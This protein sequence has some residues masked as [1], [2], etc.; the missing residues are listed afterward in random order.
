MNG[1]RVTG[2]GGAYLVIRTNWADETFDTHMSYAGRSIWLLFII[3]ICWA[4]KRCFSNP[5]RLT[6]RLLFLTTYQVEM[7]GLSP[8]SALTSSPPFLAFAD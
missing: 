2:Q 3:I 1:R 7:V 8:S 4:V 5:G 6:F